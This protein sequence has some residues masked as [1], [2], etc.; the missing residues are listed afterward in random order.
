MLNNQ[1]SIEV[2]DLINQLNPPLLLEI[3]ALREIILD[4]GLELVET[5]KWNGPNYQ[6]NHEDRIT[7]RVQD[8]KQ[9]QVIFHR[10]AKVQIQPDSR[11]IDDEFNLLTWKENDRA[12]IRFTSMDEIVKQSETIKIIVYRWINATQ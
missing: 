10:G 5:I 8:T 4:S 9:V 12:I 1:K 3:E 6:F 11:L 2:T 7:L